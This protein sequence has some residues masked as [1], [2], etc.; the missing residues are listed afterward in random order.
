MEDVAQ[1]VEDTVIRHQIIRDSPW[2]RKAV[3]VKQYA[4]AVSA[5]RARGTIQNASLIPYIPQ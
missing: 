3:F 1:L 2:S 5:F 4:T